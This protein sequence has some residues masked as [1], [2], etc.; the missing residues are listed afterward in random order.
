[1]IISDFIEEL[2]QKEIEISFIAGKLKYTG[3]E[4]QITPE[5]IENLKKYKGKLMKHFW[6]KE[7]YNMMPINTE[8]S[9]T[10]F[11]LVHGQQAN[12]VL[13]EY[14]GK[15]QP[16]YGFFHYGSNG[17]K[18]TFNNIKLLAENYI[19]QIQKVIPN[20]PYLLGGF[21]FG[22]TL[23]FEIAIQLQKSGYNVPLLILI[24][25]SNPLVKEPFKWESNLFKMLK[26]YILSPAKEEIRRIIILVICKGFLLFNK[27]T[28]VSLRSFY[29]LNAYHNMFIN[30][31]P[32]KFNGDI[33]LLKASS[34]KSFYQYLGWETL[35][36]EIKLFHI[37]GEHSTL[38]SNI[39]FYALIRAE[40]QKV[41]ASMKS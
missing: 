18:I 32:E 13:S 24:D 20:G 22:G 21:S 40:I 7:N 12:Y 25:I 8:G 26:W 29:I 35:V 33:V 27:P 3:P 17:E 4:K 14:L 10:P 16:M 28:P 6:P 41:T 39:E 30:Y 9:K 19:G 5:L 11:I 23:A 15:D 1:M 36:N 34:N 2:R 31:H 37:E 38:Y